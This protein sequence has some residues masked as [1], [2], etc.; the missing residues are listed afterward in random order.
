MNV[1]NTHCHT[2]FAGAKID[3][4]NDSDETLLHAA[5]HYG[6]LEVIEFLLETINLADDYINKQTNEKSFAIIR[7]IKIPSESWTALHF[8]CA[9]G[10]TDVVRYLLG[11]GADRSIRTG[12]GLKPI[13]LCKAYKQKHIIPVFEDR[14][15]SHLPEEEIAALS[16]ER[17][18]ARRRTLPVTNK[19][20]WVI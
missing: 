7:K 12:D 2:I 6:Q 13:E 20:D 3:V 15:A 11:H 16:H 18:H 19:P 5:A 8:A 4:M 10:H 14:R 1:Q 17:L 9:L